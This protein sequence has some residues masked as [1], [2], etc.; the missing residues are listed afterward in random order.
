MER[1]RENHTDIVTTRC[2][3]LLT[4]MWKHRW[5][6][7]H[8]DAPSALT[9]ILQRVQG[10]QYFDMTS[11]NWGSKI[12][13]ATLSH[14]FTWQKLLF[15]SYNLNSLNSVMLSAFSHHLFGISYRSVQLFSSVTLTIIAYAFCHFT[16]W[17]HI[18]HFQVQ[19]CKALMC[20]MAEWVFQSCR[21]RPMVTST[22]SP[23]ITQTRTSMYK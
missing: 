13:Y 12:P 2:R 5:A 23:G 16:F 10:M 6:H 20:V 22:H 8:T 4:D 15:I 3:D 21:E 7:T 14:S 1:N 9:K 18:F 19:F 11:L 17:E